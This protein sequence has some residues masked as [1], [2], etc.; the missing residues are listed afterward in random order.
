MGFFRNFKSDDQFSRLEQ[1][2]AITAT[3]GFILLTGFILYTLGARIAYAGKVLPGVSSAGVNLSGMTSDE[4]QQAIGSDLPYPEHGLIVL[5]D[6]DRLWATNPGELGVELDLTGIAQNALNVG[7]EGGILKRLSDQ[8]KAW[9]SGNSITP[10][11][12]F[13]QQQGAH[14]LSA[15]STQIDLQQI[16][17]QIGIDGIEIK[18]SP[19]QIGRKLDIDST[20]LEITDPI[21]NLFDADIDLVINEYPPLVLD[22]SVQAAIAE[23][24]LSEPLVL[25]AEGA[26]PWNFEQRD[27]AEMLQFNLIEDG[28][29]SRY[30]VGLSSVVLSETLQ[31]LADELDINAQNARFIFNDDSEELDLI[32]PAIIGR[33]L[34]VQATI[35]QIQ[36]DL[37]AGNHEIAL[38]FQHEEPEVGDDATAEELG[39]REPVSI[40]ST[41]FSG[42]GTA[43][44]HNV[45][46]AASAFHGVLVAPGETLSM[47]EILG[48]ISLDTGYAEALIIY[49]DRTIK[50]VGGGVCQVSTTLFRAAFFGGYPIVERYSHAYRVR[51]YEIGAS[52]PGP[53][54]DA[55]VF[56]PV[57]D[58]KFTNDR[59]DWLLLETYVYGQ[60]LVWKFYSTADGRDVE[61]SSREFNAE[62]A[63][64][65]LYKENPDLKKG[66]IKQVDW[67]ADGLDVIVTRIV[68]RNGS[69]LYED[70]IET[71]Y[72]PW[73]AIFEYGPGTELTKD[74]KTEIDD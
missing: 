27:L 5:H 47:A 74:A 42:S 61:W 37:K 41:Y 19:G 16:D 73:R 60:Q 64:E 26:G 57:V 8:W 11:V 10:V 18:M 35:D 28:D 62:D 1:L 70:S 3:G 20:L 7:R 34:D 50:G 25:T 65:A 33:R 4:V 45:E 30:E 67:A 51:Y 66:E 6:A 22:A 59:P 17:A 39:I 49:G 63:P 23:T 52:S 55:T 72:L 31:A 13:D 43:R 38:V 58:F 24:I 44:A 21:A 40:V 9:F 56:V 14:Y 36:S 46:T 29:T 71:H 48:D 32:E 53:G 69:S 2:A 54:F 12:I 15:L 68:T